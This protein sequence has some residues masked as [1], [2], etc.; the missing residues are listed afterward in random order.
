MICSAFAEIISIGM[1]IPFLSAITS[2]DTVFAHPMMQ[3]LVKLFNVNSNSEL[4]IL[5]TAL[6]CVLA[7]FAAGMRLSTLWFQTRFCYAVGQH[8]STQLYKNTLYQSYSMHV[9]RNSSEFIS[10]IVNKTFQSTSF[11]ILPILN[12]FSSG[13]IL[14]AIT[15]TLIF[16]QPLVA[17]SAF[18]LF[19]SAYGAV[20]ILTKAKLDLDSKKISTE[21]DQV[22][23][24]LQEG[25]GSIR[26]ILVSSTQKVYVKSYTTSYHSLQRAWANVEIIKA[27]PRFVIEAIG[28]IIIALLALFYYE[29]PGG[30]AQALPILGAMAL[31]AQRMLPMLQV[32]YASLAALRAGLASLTD[33][34]LM[35]DEP[36]SESLVNESKQQILFNDSITLENLKFQYNPSSPKVLSGINTRI[37][38]GSMTGI[39][40]STGSGKSTLID[41]IMG[42]LQPS[43]GKF[44]VDGEIITETNK[45]GWQELLAHVPQ[46]IFLIDASIAEN[47]ALG[48]SPE[49]IDHE[50]VQKSA[51]QAH[52][53]DAISSW[54]DKY[55]TVVGERGVRLS[56]GQRQRIAI[57][58]ALYKKAS[59]IIFDEATSALDSETESSVME[60]ITSLAEDITIIIV[61]HRLSTL[62]ECSNIIELSNGKI[63]RQ[64][65]YNEIVKG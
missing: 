35:L 22:V 7:I 53:H 9:A 33:I 3:S 16:I 51:K 14:L 65:V 46:S 45:Y 12:I 55:E 48:I 2:P 21:Q 29:Q 56:G 1:I 38:K 50:L 19:G 43:E 25:F 57:A 31:G 27:T 24:K 42:L 11:A 28:I 17:L 39:I 64:G 54:D 41:I 44:K 5:L 13:F 36:T 26:D 15:A 30:I 60:A 34:F 10:T 47:I 49:E 52:I 20:I 23:K 40:G 32:I 4:V 61:A 37:V 8:L 58:R 59:V 63:V 18:M 62:K 6:F